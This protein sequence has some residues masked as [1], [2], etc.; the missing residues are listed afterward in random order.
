MKLVSV[1]ARLR[2]ADAD[3]NIPFF[4][5][6]GH[7]AERYGIVGIGDAERKIAMIMCAGCLVQ[8][9]RAIVDATG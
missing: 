3:V 9:P 7:D 5:I 2:V 4:K 1:D 6:C 8:V